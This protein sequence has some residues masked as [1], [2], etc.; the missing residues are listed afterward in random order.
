MA[1]TRI[2]NVGESR[3]HGKTSYASAGA[4][5]KNSLEYI[6]NP[7]KTNA[8]LLT[9]SNIS[10]DPGEAYQTMIDT[11]REWNEIL[12][13][14]DDD[15]KKSKLLGRQGYHMVI[16]WSP[17]EHVD[18]QT[19]YQVIQEFCQKYLGDSY[20]YAFSVHTD[21]R[22]MHGHIVFN[23][24]NRETGYKYRYEKGDWKKYMQPLTDEI[25]ERYGLEKLVYDE[26]RKGKSYAEHAAE[27]DNR[28]TNTRIIQNDIDYAASHAASFEEYLE[29]MRQFG[30]EVRAGQSKKYGEY[31]T[32]HM[33]GARNAR[34]DRNLRRRDYKLGRGYRMKDIEERIRLKDFTVFEHKKSPRLKSMKLDGSLEKRT[35]MNRYQVRYVRRMQHASGAFYTLKNPY[36]VDQRQVRR[37]M[38]R[39][40]RLARE[41]RYLLRTNLGSIEAVKKRLADVRMM[42]TFLIRDLKIAQR[43][44]GETDPALKKNMNDLKLKLALKND[45]DNEYENM[46][47]DLEKLKDSYTS[48]NF[49][50]EPEELMRQLQDVREEKK[51]LA[52]IVR[53][54]KE[55]ADEADRL[56][57][58]SF[59][60][61]KEMALN[62][63]RY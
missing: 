33:P 61:G 36:K 40:D 59:E 47:D 26:R 16:S 43:N 19:A 60:K 14:R 54:E 20:E 22:H 49:D 6:L 27:K 37:D 32:Y 34:S 29:I 28:M 41:C 10:T 4:H 3:S 56:R 42:E 12:G 46:E 53:E 13:I 9:G 1:I 17:D 38:L 55:A 62:V 58:K 39:I 31:L 63:R 51:I 7:E 23:S 2:I 25:C 50:R 21:Q 45:L 48:G 15:A 30:Y 24:V 35:Y 57:E 18:A 44:A 11:K 52:G 5:L 8:G